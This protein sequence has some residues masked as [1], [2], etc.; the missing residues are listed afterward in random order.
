VKRK[1]EKINSEG[2]KKNMGDRIDKQKYYK[3]KIDKK[4]RKMR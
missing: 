2:I 3:Y 1:S 4:L